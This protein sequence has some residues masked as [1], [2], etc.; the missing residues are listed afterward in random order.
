MDYS[1]SGI[2]Y[3]TDQNDRTAA[4]NESRIR[5]NASAVA[6]A[7]TQRND[8]LL[9]AEIRLYRMALSQSERDHLDACGCS[10]TKIQLYA[11]TSLEAATGIIISSVPIR[12]YETGKEQWVCFGNLTSIYEALARDDQLKNLTITL[13]V[14]SPCGLRQLGFTDVDGHDPLLVAYFASSSGGLGIISGAV[15]SSV[16]NQSAVRI[17]VRRRASSPCGLVSYQVSYRER[18]LM[19][20]WI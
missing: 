16:Y 12:S 20:T 13:V 2:A 7:V 11:T 15:L 5:F 10:S 1:A 4:A 17:G 19:Y 9:S 18:L 8:T 14:R 3:Y 6:S